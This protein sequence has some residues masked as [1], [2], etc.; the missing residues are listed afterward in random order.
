MIQ[1]GAF[2]QSRPLPAEPME[3]MVQSANYG[4]QVLQSAIAQSNPDPIPAAVGADKEAPAS[5]RQVRRCRG[6]DMYENEVTNYVF[7]FASTEG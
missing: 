1:S 6:T 7:V 3:R 4:R 5:K 2:I